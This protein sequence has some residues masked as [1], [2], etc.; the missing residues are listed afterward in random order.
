MKASKI[1]YSTNCLLAYRINQLYYDDKHYV[2]AAS[3]AG[4]EVDSDCLLANPP[5][6]QPMH[7]YKQLALESQRGDLH[8]LFIKEQKTGIRRGAEVK[9][10]ARIISSKQKK[11]IFKIVEL[12]TPPDFKPLMYQMTYDDVKQLISIP[13][14]GELAHPCS[15]EF[16]ILSLPR[17]LFRVHDF[18][19]LMV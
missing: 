16:L 5:T 9:Y 4:S 8:G 1:L 3:E 17:E 19:E 15:S 13:D 11:D 12:S 7:R 14:I 18:S 10:E 2:W 6:S